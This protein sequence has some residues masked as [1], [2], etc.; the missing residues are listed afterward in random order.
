MN[1]SKIISRVPV[2]GRVSLENS[3]RYCDSD[4]TVAFCVECIARYNVVAISGSGRFSQAVTYSVL[5]R[6]ITLPTTHSIDVT[7]QA[8]AAFGCACFAAR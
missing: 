4:F 5:S 6:N 3:I 8:S 1:L 2:P 7:L